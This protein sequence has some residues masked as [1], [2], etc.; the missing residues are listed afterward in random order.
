MPDVDTPSEASTDTGSDP[1]VE[2]V[3]EDE[4]KDEEA[5]QLSEQVEKQLRVQENVNQSAGDVVPQ[6]FE[7]DETDDDLLDLPEYIV[8]RVASL[9]DLHEQRDKIME[10]YLK[11]RAALEQKYQGLYQPLYDERAQII[12]GARDGE[13]VE[14]ELDE[15]GEPKVVGIPSFWL[16]V[17][18]HYEV[19]GA[20]ITEEDESCLQH[21]QD[22]KCIDDADATGFKLEFHFGPNEFFKNSVLTKTYEVPNLLLND[23]PILKNVHGC[24][25]HWVEGKELTFRQVVKKQRGTGKNA[26]DTRTVTKKERRDS[27]FH[28][29]DPPTM[30]PMSDMNEEEADRLERVFDHDFDVAQ[31]FR[32]QLIPKVRFITL[33]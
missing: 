17:M 32:T 26:G 7:V 29:F 18:H 23:E 22:V 24:K 10:D 5:E 3:D 12:A 14:G 19:V 16:T 13:Q 15:T 25:I 1:V 27:F 30:P 2:A 8:Q 6:V 33:Y 11:E 20:L 21:L 9:L 28:F 4:E 31:A